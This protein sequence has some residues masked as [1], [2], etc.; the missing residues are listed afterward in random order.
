MMKQTLLTITLLF[1][2]VAAAAFAK[3]VEEDAYV[4]GVEDVLEV[5]ILQPEKLTSQAA[6]SPDG[7]ISLPYV[8]NVIVNGMTLNQIKD[9]VQAEL[10]NGYMK[11]PLVFVSLKESHSKKFFVYGN[12]AKP[13]S[14]ALT[15]KT[16]VLN[17]I[18]I[19][20]GLSKYDPSSHV[21]VLRLNT[22]SGDY[23]TIDVDV[24][25]AAKG[26]S[27]QDIILSPGD[28]VTV[29]EGKF[30]VYGEVN[31][32]GAYSFEGY[33]TVMKAIA[34]AGGFT[35]FG[36]ASRV[37]VLR[38][39]PGGLGSETIKIN[40]KEATTGYTDSD[41]MLIPGDTVVVME[42]VF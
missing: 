32:P 4:V 26:Q 12:V 25:V 15:E 11:Y 21:R 38:P 7:S 35:K 33:T 41:I 39:R 14:Y 13:G 40:I 27:A 30:F 1:F 24:G 34:I 10:A 36:S 20:G 29:S 17:A 23:E 16:T 31:K 6:V 8:G 5:N 18:A 28:T 2:V 42:G 19:A 3:N 22:K 9:K 37:K